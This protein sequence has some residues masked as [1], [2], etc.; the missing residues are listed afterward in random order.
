[1]RVSSQVTRLSVVLICLIGSCF[2]SSLRAL[3][4]GA[5]PSLGAAAAG[6]PMGAPMPNDASGLPENDVSPMTSALPDP[7]NLGASPSA[8][9]DL[10]AAS[11]L[12]PYSALNADSTVAPNLAQNVNTALHL[13]I[14][15]RIKDVEDLLNRMVWQ[16]NRETAWANSVHDIIKNYQYKYTKVLSN[17]KKHTTS[18]QK[19]RELAS[20]L[21][22]A[23]LHEVLV[24]DLDKATKALTELASA[25]SDTSTDEGSYASLKD[26]VSLLKQDL[27]KMSNTKVNK[28][29]HGVQDKLKS[30]ATEAVPPPS[31]DTLKGLLSDDQKK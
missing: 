4:G 8:G 17:I 16:L 14:D 21:K 10:G 25:S 30:A 20:S 26:R 6:D 29:L 19:M 28:V 22:K 9:L 23:R 15:R 18:V 2:G 24:T 13:N 5:D 27:D 7:L 12:P 31:A 3:Q 11:T 1:M